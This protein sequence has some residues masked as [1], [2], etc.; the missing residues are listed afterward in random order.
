[1]SQ[2]TSISTIHVSNRWLT[3]SLNCNRKFRVITKWKMIRETIELCEKMENK[4]LLF[5]NRCHHPPPLLPP[6]SLVVATTL[7]TYTLKSNIPQFLLPPP[8]LAFLHHHHSS[9]AVTTTIEIPITTINVSLAGL[10][11]IGTLHVI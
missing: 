11:L 5:A 4:Y 9:P 7:F 1:M 8:H 6:L 3:K 10:N 2:V